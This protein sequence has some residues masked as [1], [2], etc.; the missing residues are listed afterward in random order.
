MVSNGPIS[1]ENSDIMYR[2]ILRKTRAGEMIINWKSNEWDSVW[3]SSSAAKGR[4][5]HYR[6]NFFGKVRDA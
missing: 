3:R 1:P 6:L 4:G 2:V 5:L